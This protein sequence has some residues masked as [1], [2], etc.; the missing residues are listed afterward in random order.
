LSD[1]GEE[2]QRCH[3]GDFIPA[4][5][6]LQTS[7]PG[8]AIVDA[9]CEINLIAFREAKK[10]VAVQ[11]LTPACDDH[12]VAVLAGDLLLFSGLVAADA[13]GVVEP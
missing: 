5:S 11:G 8:F 3:F 1:T 10:A 13:N 2:E 12:P 7:Q 4:T 9:R 6:F